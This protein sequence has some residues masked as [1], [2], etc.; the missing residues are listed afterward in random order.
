[1]LNYNHLYYFHVAAEE[2][3]VSRA[4]ERLGVTQSTVSEQI[5]LLERALDATLFERTPSGLR[6]TEQGELAFE[7]TAA[8]FRSGARLVES[9]KSA[10]EPPIPSLTVGISAA[11]SRTIAADF[12]LPF[13][14]L[15]SWVPNIV[16][17]ETNELIRSLRRS[18]FD[19]LL[20]ECEPSP[21]LRHDLTIVSLYT[22]PLVAIVGTSVEPL[23]DWQ[24]LGL[25][26]YRTSSSYRW[27]VEEHLDEH[28]LRPRTVCETDDSGFMIEAV[29]RGDIVAFVP[30]GLARD[31]LAANRVRTL[32]TL[33]KSSAPVFALYPSAESAIAARRAVDLL[34]RHARG[35]S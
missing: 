5:R 1:M 31:A 3:M 28:G 10:S 33:E 8:M 9:F 30:R 25:V 18:D 35:E 29:S 4:A 7:H 13:V 11:V 6:L 2:G 32:F 20:C 21:A 24:N 16:V 12:L 15:E 34:A 27:E 22:S 14:R 19:L 23:V 26:Q 17:G